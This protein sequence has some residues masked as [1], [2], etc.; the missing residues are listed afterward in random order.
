M[1]QKRYLTVYSQERTTGSPADLQV[2]VRHGINYEKCELKMTA[3][4][5][6]YFIIT[7]NNN[8]LLI[9]GSLV[10]IPPG[11][12]NLDEFFNTFLNLD[13]RIKGISYNDVTGVIT[14][15][16]SISVTI[17]FPSTGSINY[18]IGFP[19]DYSFTGT[20]FN[21]SFPPSLAK[22]NLYIEVDQLSSNHT[23][24]NAISGLFTYEIPN[25]NEIIQ[26]YQKSHYKQATN[27][28]TNGETL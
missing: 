3:I 24:I 5:N 15:T 16:T 25:K 8:G 27:C 12:Y 19:P 14:F 28:K 2:S 6:T 11:N 23:T 10:T 4:P 17:Y 1:S 9:N 21:S 18:I 22:F 7:S 20:S 13:I 26:Y